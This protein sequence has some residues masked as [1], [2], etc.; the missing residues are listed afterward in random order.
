MKR[1]AIFGSQGQLGV[2]LAA[3]FSARSYDVVSFGRADVDI[4][5]PDAVSRA[6]AQ[7]DPQI[8]LNPAAFNQVDLAEQNPVAAFQ[9]NAL[10]VRNIAVACRDSGAQLVHYSTDYVL[11]RKSTRLNSSH[12]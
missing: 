2:E 8:V 10:A 12:T 9:V 11:D 1:V 7:A 5:D 4:T 3:T 6:I